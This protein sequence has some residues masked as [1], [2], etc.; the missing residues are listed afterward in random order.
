MPGRTWCSIR[1]IDSD[2]CVAANSKQASWSMSLTSRSPRPGSVN[3]P[4]AFSGRQPSARSSS[5]RNAGASIHSAGR[6]V[7][8]GPKN[9]QPAMPIR[10][11]PSL[12]I[13][14]PRRMSASG[15]LA[16]RSWQTR[17]RLW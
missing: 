5:T 3:S 11:A 9:F 2:P 15:G 1:R 6:P 14:A 4:V 16:D 12:P 8:A 7:S 13:P 17:L 10:V